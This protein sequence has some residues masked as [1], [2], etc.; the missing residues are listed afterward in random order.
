LKSGGARE[1]L[2]HASIVGSVGNMNSNL[3]RGAFACNSKAEKVQNDV[4]DPPTVRGEIA[5]QFSEF[6]ASQI[7]RFQV[8]HKGCC[9]HPVLTRGLTLVAQGVR[10]SQV[11]TK[12][13]TF[14]PKNGISISISPLIEG[15]S[16]GLTY[17]LK[18]FCITMGR[19]GGGC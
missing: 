17:Q 1:D 14:F 3:S 8:G 7:A 13:L 16:K 11:L 6:I 10:E 19:I 12:S 15:P 5:E 9:A 4:R 2:V 18:Q